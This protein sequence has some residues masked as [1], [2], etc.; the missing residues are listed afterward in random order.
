MKRT[1]KRILTFILPNLF[2]FLVLFSYSTSAAQTPGTFMPTGNMTTP[3]IFHTATLL[4][5]GKVLIAGGTFPTRPGVSVGLAS[6][7]VFDPETGTFTATGNMITGRLGHSSTLLHD[8]RVLIVGGTSDS[9]FSDR[10][11]TAEIYDPDT[12]TFSST[13]S[14]VTAQAGHTATLLN[15]GK[16]LI[17]GG[18]T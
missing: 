7:E 16:V 8:G 5:N 14:M 12:E 11:A 18:G 9:D 15:N 3:R 4:L 2:L 17:A 1:G 13:G 6:A 10:L